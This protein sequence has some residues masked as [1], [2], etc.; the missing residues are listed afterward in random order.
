MRRVILPEVQLCQRK[1]IYTF[2]SEEAWNLDEDEGTVQSQLEGFV[3]ESEIPE[4]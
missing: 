1:N 3:M 4:S 2:P